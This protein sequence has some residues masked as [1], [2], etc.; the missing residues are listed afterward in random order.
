MGNALRVRRKKR[1]QKKK[2]IGIVP[3]NDSQEPDD[4]YGRIW[5]DDSE[6]NNWSTEQEKCYD[7]RDPTLRFVDGPDDL[8]FLYNDYK[9][10]RAKMSCGHAVTP[11]SLT[12][13]CH[14]L[15]DEGD[16][17]FVC[18]QTNCDVE[19]PFEEVCKMALLSPE[20][21]E[22]FEKKMFANA[23]KDYMDVKAGC[24]GGLWLSIYPCLSH[25]WFAGGA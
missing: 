9:S 22:Y 11:M 14:H 4:I 2:R 19:W 13:W 12:D 20:E 16:C 23:A 17:K 7:P 5:D 18:G 15:L 6:S 24:E 1:K 3:V 8:D 25:L 10:L 21:I